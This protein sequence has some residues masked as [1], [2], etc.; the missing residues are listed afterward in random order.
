MGKKFHEVEIGEKMVGTSVTMTETHIVLFAGL[1]GDYYPLHLNEE[2]AKKSP[3]KGRIA[4]GPLSFVIGLGM[5]ASQMAK[6]DIVA[7]LGF[8][9]TKFTAPVKLGDTITPEAEVLDKVEK[10]NK[11]IVT[12][13]LQVKTQDNIVAVESIFKMMVNN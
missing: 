3:F 8:E 10:G 9:S 2:F 1:T 13:R 7:A 6:W 4:H 12:L 11:G 5:I